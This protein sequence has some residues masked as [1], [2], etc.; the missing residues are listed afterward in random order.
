MVVTVLAGSAL[1]VGYGNADAADPIG[2]DGVVTTTSGPIHGK[3]TDD[4]ARFRDVPYAAPPVGQRRWKPPRAPQPWTKTRDAT[5]PGPKCVQAASEGGIDKKSSEDCLTL[6]VTAPRG[7][8]DKPRPVMVW[9]HGGGLI[10]GDGASF[11]PSRMADRGDVVV[12]SINYRLGV[13][14]YFGYPGMSGSGDFGLQDQQAAL[15]WVHRNAAA[16][17]GDARN[18]TLFGE[19]AGGYATCAQSIAPGT[20]HLISKAIFQSGTCS[21]Q[22]WMFAPGKTTPLP[23]AGEYWSPVGKVQKRGSAAAKDLKC[24]GPAALKCLRDKKPADLM[25]QF[26]AFASP[27]Y[28]TPTLPVDP[29]KALGHDGRRMPTM[30][31]NTSDESRYLTAWGEYPDHPVDDKEFAKLTDA[32]FGD[33]ADTVRAKYPLKPGVAPEL[34]WA[35][36]DTDRSMACPQ[37]ADGRRLA[38]R[39][40]TYAYE[41]ADQTSPPI[42]PYPPG[43]TMPTGGSHGSELL[44][45]LDTGTVDWQGHPVKLNAKQRALG[46]AMIGYWTRFA[47]TG[48]PNGSTD[49]HWSTVDATSGSPRVQSL[50]TGEH[51]IAPVDARRLHHCDFWDRYDGRS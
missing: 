35:R 51:G 15:R 1:A 50:A 4:V 19:S 11:D 9:T 17:G 12:V 5:K 22:P 30:V 38:A 16:F 40:D 32:A 10:Q 36:L 23:D 8:S 31:G 14:G 27:A 46:D 33:N 44:Y 2:G 47:H 13:F 7:A 28:G 48:D 43:S 37:I 21:G 42:G 29:K 45:L 18:V 26:A 24:A 34:T 20:R 39:S 49:P 41:F 3:L 25:G 6:E